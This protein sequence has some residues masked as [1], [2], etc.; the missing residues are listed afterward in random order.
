MEE[1][2]AALLLL[3]HSRGNRITSSGGE[4]GVDVRVSNPNGYDIYQVKRYSQALTANQAA[5]VKDSWNTF[6]AETLPAL[7]VRSWTL[8]TPW[9]PA[10]ERLDWLER[11]TADSGIPSTGWGISLD[12]MAA[13]KPS[14]LEFFFGDGGQRLQRLM[15][16]A[17][18][19]GRRGAPRSGGRGSFSGRHHAPPQPCEHPERSGPFLPLRDR[20]PAMCY[21]PSTWWPTSR[22]PPVLCWRSGVAGRS[23]PCGGQKSRP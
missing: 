22:P 16:E 1:D 19:G 9:Q 12:G 8:V 18:Q 17:L 7:P 5:R 14:L 3:N 2:V 15:T 13:E 6:A 21:R 10:N 23:L 11:L 4:R 20:D